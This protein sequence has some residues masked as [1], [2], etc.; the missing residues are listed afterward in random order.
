MISNHYHSITLRLQ[1]SSSNG[2]TTLKGPHDFSAADNVPRAE[3]VRV[4]LQRIREQRNSKIQ[5]GL[6]TIDGAPL[7]VKHRIIRISLS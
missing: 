3:E 1:L 2:N 7:K 4:L 5:A 6:P